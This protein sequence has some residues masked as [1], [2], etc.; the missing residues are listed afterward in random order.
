MGSSHNWNSYI[1]LSLGALKVVEENVLWFSYQF[2]LH[3]ALGRPSTAF[4]AQNLG[5]IIKTFFYLSGFP[6]YVIV[7]FSLDL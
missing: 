3:S 5:K 1:Q 6:I 4:P 2:Y 7:I